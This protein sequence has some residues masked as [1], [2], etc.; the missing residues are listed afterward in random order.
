ML[1]LV[2][3]LL[4]KI[5][6]KNKECENHMKESR[7]NLKDWSFIANSEDILLIIQYP[8]TE[9]EVQTGYQ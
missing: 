5:V 4:V 8:D 2:F 1:E 3:D 9:M 7:G 6:F